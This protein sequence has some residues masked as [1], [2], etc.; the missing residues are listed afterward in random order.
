VIDHDLMLF[1]EPGVI[2]SGGNSGFQALNL[3]AQFGASKII[4]IG[5]DMHSAR[6]VHWYGPNRGR[7]MRN[8]LEHNYV[9]WRGALSKQARVLAG[10]GVQVVNVS[11]DSA[12]D[13][14]VRM[15]IDEALRWAA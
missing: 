6:G 1:D 11:P 14:F 5:F 10:M 3:A 4:L 9:S 2:G 13:C 8:P 15:P 7:D 12:L